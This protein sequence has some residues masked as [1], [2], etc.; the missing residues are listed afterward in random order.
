MYVIP[1]VVVVVP[2]YAFV[3]AWY[4]CVVWLVLHGALD[5]FYFGRMWC[6]FLGVIVA[7]VGCCVVF[8]CGED[9]NLY[10]RVVASCTCLF[11][12]FF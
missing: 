5:G 11:N 7:C 1:V 6:L 10:N 9:S 4:V 8:C 3:M 12:Y 2:W